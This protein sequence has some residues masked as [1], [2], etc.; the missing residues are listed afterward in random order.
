MALRAGYYGIKKNVLAAISNLSGAKIIKSIG[1]G[2]KLTSAGKLSCDIDTDTMEF[3]AGKLSA[4]GKGSLDLIAGT[5]VIS[6][7]TAL[8]TLDISED[9]DDYD[10]I[11]LSSV[12]Y[13]NG[14]T[15]V[16]DNVITVDVLK[17]LTGSSITAPHWL[18]SMN[19]HTDTWIRIQYDNGVL[20]VFNSP[21]GVGMGCVYGIKY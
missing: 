20:K 13:S 6:E 1:D 7:M 4:K 17:Q 10:A 19:P 8:M 16:V 14:V 3:K 18:I 5:N 15:A 11:I 9:V 21:V 2:L 12:F